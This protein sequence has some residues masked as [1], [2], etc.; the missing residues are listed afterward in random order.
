MKRLAT[1][2][3]RPVN[4]FKRRYVARGLILIYHRVGED[5]V[6]PW[7]LC[8]SPGNFARQLEVIRAMGFRTVRVSEMADALRAGH[9]PRRTIAVTFD[10]GYRDNLEAARPILERYETP[11]SHYAT[12][13]YIGA[14]EPF[15]WD[16]LDLVFL[17]PGH[18]PDTVEITLAGKLHRWSL[19]EDAVLKPG[20]ET[21][22]PDW[23]PFSPAPTRR[24][25]VHDSLWTLLVAALPE[26]RNR[27]V[28]QLLDW[29]GVKP[30]A[31]AGSR[32]MSEVELRALRGDG[33]VEIGAHSLTHPALSALPPASQAHELNASKARLEQILGEKVVG[34]SYPNGRSSSQ[35][36]QLA[37]EAGYDFACGSVA[38]AVGSRSNL[39]HLPR[40]S[41][42]DWGEARFKALL[43]HNIV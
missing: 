9:L 3:A 1:L 5:P 25:A 31:W 24:H 26:E 16:A 35:V 11:A 33:L 38:G 32:P 28:R 23:R 22:W 20:Q 36:Q 2:A 42:R 39:F 15:W 41:A 7:R 10:D 14:D 37:R 40:V 8:V 43:T 18:L 13:G 30:K 6:D 4:A 34:C 21:R 17:R 29:A 27:V 12:A 19:G